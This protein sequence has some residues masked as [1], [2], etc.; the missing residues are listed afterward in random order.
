MFSKR[1]VK[2]GFTIV[3]LMVGMLA[4]SVMALVVA[5]M[6]IYGWRGW[7]RSRELVSMQREAS[8]SMLMIVKEIR[9]STY[10]G[11]TDGSGISFSDTGSS[12]SESGNSIIS[13]DGFTLVDG[14]LVPGTFLTSKYQDVDAD[15]RKE[16]WVDV[17]FTL[18]TSSEQESFTI[19]AVPRNGS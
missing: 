13:D 16:Q 3:E 14:W 17:S 11:I 19:S 1:T 9:N 2:K 10:A 7:V 15:G 8:L 18:K 12:F 5:T 4:F 6:L